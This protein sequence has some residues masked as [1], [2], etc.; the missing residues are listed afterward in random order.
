MHVARFFSILACLL[1]T[2]SKLSLASVVDLPTPSRMY[3]YDLASRLITILA[4]LRKPR[5]SDCFGHRKATFRDKLLLIGSH[6]QRTQRASTS[7]STPRQIQCTRFTLA[8]SI[9]PELGLACHD[10]GSL[11]YTSRGHTKSN[12][13]TALKAPV[14][15]PSKCYALYIYMYICATFTTS[16]Y[17]HL[18]LAGEGLGLGA[19]HG[20]ITLPY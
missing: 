3:H 17:H 19:E 7:L 10:M 5:S 2:L 11:L 1:C 15:H 9:N 13:R 12:T 18:L 6:I 8:I 14:G 16:Q 4:L 20:H